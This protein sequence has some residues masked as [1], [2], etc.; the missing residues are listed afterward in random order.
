VQKGWIRALKGHVVDLSTLVFK[1][2]EPLKISFFAETI[3]KIL[4]AADVS[5]THRAAYGAL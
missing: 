4:V 1:G 3:S 5:Q 2:D